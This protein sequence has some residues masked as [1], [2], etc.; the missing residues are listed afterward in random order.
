MPLDGLAHHEAARLAC[1]STSTCMHVFRYRACAKAQPAHHQW[2]PF[3]VCMF[4]ECIPAFGCICRPIHICICM[5]PELCAEA[6]QSPSGS[7][8]DQR[9]RAAASGTNPVG[10]HPRRIAAKKYWMYSS[11]RSGSGHSATTTARRLAISREIIIMSIVCAC[12]G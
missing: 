4:V 9:R 3:D 2:G 1:Q 7:R 12:N 8:S 6:M 5:R 10:V 11:G